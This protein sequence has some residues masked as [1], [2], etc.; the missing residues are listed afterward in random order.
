[1]TK[2]ELSTIASLNKEIALLRNNLAETSYG[3]G[4]IVTDKVKG[5]SAHFPYAPR[6]FTISGME[7]MSEDCIKKRNQIAHRIDAKM[8]KLLE[9]VQAAYGYIDTIEDSTIRQI[10]I[11]TYVNNV[12]QEQM[13]EEMG[14]SLTTVQRKF[15]EWRE[16]NIE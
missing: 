7:Q 5:S 2:K 11:Y 13:A 3:D 1:M 16:A 4:S 10:L 8:Q 15:R 6:R 9:T 14:I 12:S